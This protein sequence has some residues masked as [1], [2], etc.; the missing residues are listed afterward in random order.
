M[1][2]SSLAT[3]NYLTKTPALDNGEQTS[4]NGKPT[5]VIGKPSLDNEKSILDMEIQ[6]WTM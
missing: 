3:Q 6:I 5:L 4:V 2:D 1:H